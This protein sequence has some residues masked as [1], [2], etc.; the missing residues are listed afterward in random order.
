[1]DAERDSP[2]PCRDENLTGSCLGKGPVHC[3]PPPRTLRTYDPSD[4]F[5]MNVGTDASDVC[6]VKSSAA[7]NRAS[8][9][10]RP[11]SLAVGRMGIL[12]NK[13]GGGFESSGCDGQ[14]M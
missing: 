9:L 10:A 3:A 5:A 13:R 1:M 12:P 7:E 4:A 11:S 14:Q 8:A 2:I 6:G